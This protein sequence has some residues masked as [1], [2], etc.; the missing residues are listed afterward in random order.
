M[1]IVQVTAI[2]RDRGQLTIPDKIREA[3]KWP[4]PNSVVS[5]ITTFRNELV[6]IPYERQK[7]VNWSQ[8]WSNIKESRSYKGKRG[9][10]S[11]FIVSDRENH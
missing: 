3:L 11:S 8:V 4:I 1:S 6:I 2:I 7:K 5:L 9:N 10:L